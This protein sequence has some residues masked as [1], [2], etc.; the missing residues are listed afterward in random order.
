MSTDTPIRSRR[1]G[2]A[3]VAVAALAGILLGAGGS[4]LALWNASASRTGSIS[5][6][7]EFFAAG[8][9]G[10]TQAAQGNRI[11]VS[12]G[13]AEAK[14]LVAEGKVA[15]PFQTDSLS[16]GNLG[17]RYTVEGPADWGDG[18][19]GASDTV[20]FP[21]AGAADCSVSRA[22]QQQPG[23]TSTPVDAAYS[24]TE[25]PTTEFWCLVATVDRLPGEGA[26]ANTATATAKAPDASQVTAKDQWAT[27]VSTSVDPA[28]EPDHQITFTYETFRPGEVT[29]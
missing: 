20:I 6:G 25:T 24:S 10:A 11:S 7:A 16:Q 13:E 22:P 27:Q 18:V 14:T 19:F 23:L 3:V 26:Y 4:T 17:L 2:M 21:V 1:R 5:S 15:V 9:P 29:P 12:V 8:R 28:D